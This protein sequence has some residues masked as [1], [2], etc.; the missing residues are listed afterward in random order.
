RPQAH[1]RLPWD[2]SEALLDADFHPGGQTAFIVGEGGIVLRFTR[3]DSAV[4]SAGG[5]LYFGQTELRAVS[6]NSDGSWAYIGGE[7]GWIW[8]VRGLEGGG[9]EVHPIEGRGT[10][11]VNGIACLASTNMCIV[12]TSVDGIGVIDANHEL[13]WI[14]GTG[15]PWIDATCPS[16]GEDACVAISNDRNIAIVDIDVGDTSASDVSI[17]QLQDVDGQFNGIAGQSDG[18]SIVFVVPYSMIEHD[19]GL[20]LSFPWLENA[21]A[22][23]YDP[24]IA[25]ERLV[26][27]WATSEYTGWA[28]TGP[29][30]I[31]A[32]SPV[33]DDRTG[34][35]LGIWMG[36]VIVGGAI[37]M[38]LSL[39]VS[40]SPRLSRWLTM[41]VG[42]E[43]ERK[44]ARREQRRKD[45]R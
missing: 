37:G 21:D 24:A 12:S 35:I 45:R 2:G 33:P 36:V 1:S 16:K 11:D 20:R 10:S 44:E 8:R 22:V 14:G 15:Y 4:G 32:F 31:V 38:I 40:S 29:G 17:V 9:M 43:E 27:T 23:S 6:W 25:G 19:L 34:G 7:M 3:A 42:S 5:E 18:K 28:L 39:I 30:T 26:A 41:R 13:H